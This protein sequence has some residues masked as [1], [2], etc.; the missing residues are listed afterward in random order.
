MKL[1][2]W[3]KETQIDNQEGKKTGKLAD[4]FERH[5]SREL[6]KEAGGQETKEG[7]RTESIK[8]GKRRVS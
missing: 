4:I 2:R 8:A 1:I 6:S 3:E 7:V 5:P